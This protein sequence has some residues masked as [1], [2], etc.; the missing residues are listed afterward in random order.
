MQLRAE[1]LIDAPA[2]A[3]WAVI[4]ERFG[5]IADWAAPI[6][7][8]SLDG[9]LAVGAT[10]TCQVAQFGPFAPGV[11]KERLLAFD[12]LAM[13]LR[14]ESTAGLPRFVK[15]ATNRWSVDPRTEATCLVRT[16]ATLELQGP[17]RL[18]SMLFARVLQA[19]A[20]RVLKDLQ[21]YV[22]YSRSL[23]RQ[24]AAA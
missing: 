15:S 17:I 22:E 12:G 8:S 14:Y 11:V 5:D 2:A 9:E 20:I 18:L 13:S 6:R 21:R 7:A 19:E 3:A 4:G 23:P 1:V 16:E 10:R 24:H